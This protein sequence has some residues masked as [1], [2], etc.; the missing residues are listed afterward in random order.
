M[1]MSSKAPSPLGPFI[2]SA[3][4][5]G[6]SD[7]FLVKLLQS[8][9]WPE[10][11]IYNALNAVYERWTGQPTPAPPRAARGESR[12]AFF[13]GL[14]H[15]AM[16]VW[17]GSLAIITFMYIDQWFPLRELPRNPITWD[18]LTGPLAAILVALPTHL[19]VARIMA[20][21]FELY[22]EKAASQVRK[23]VIYFTLFVVSTIAIIDL[24]SFLTALLRGGLSFRFL[25]QFATI[26]VL[27]GG[28]FWYDTSSLRRVRQSNVEPRIEPLSG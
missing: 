22:P 27:S 14:E 21:D 17:V 1:A 6:A 15:L 25:M 16:A 5:K 24:I 28:V 12:D 4:S 18:N 10:E 3:K 20:R 11:E 13:L 8:R 23:K 2:E 7:E 19:L 9:G 26:L